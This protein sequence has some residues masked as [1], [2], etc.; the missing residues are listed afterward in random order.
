[1]RIRVGVVGAHDC[2]D[3][4]ATLAYEVGRRLAQR[5]A[6]VVTGGLAGVMYHACRGAAEGGG[7]TIG[8]LPGADAAAANQY[9]A[10]PIPTGMGEL[11]NGLIVRASQGVIAVGGGWGTLSEIALARRA[12]VPLVGLAT[13]YPET[14]DFPRMQTAEEAVSFIL[15]RVGGPN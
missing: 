2:G 15:D 14:L 4:E 11:R 8:L 9:V 7:L 10:I 12:E 3:R 5:G 13:P 1:M 6:V